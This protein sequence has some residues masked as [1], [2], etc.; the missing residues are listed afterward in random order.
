MEMETDRMFV[1]TQMDYRIPIPTQQL[2][3]L[4]Y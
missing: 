2:N 1:F 3:V 4:W